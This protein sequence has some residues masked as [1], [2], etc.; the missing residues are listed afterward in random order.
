MFIRTLWA[1]PAILML[2]A[3]LPIAPLQAADCPVPRSGDTISEMLEK[4][5]T[6]A[7]ALKMFEACGYG[8]SIDVQFGATVTEKCEGDFLPKLSASQRKVYDR[9]KDA[10]TRKYAKQEGTMYRSFEAFCRAKLAAGYARKF[11]YIGADLTPAVRPWPFPRS[12]G[13]PPARRWRDR[14]A[15]CGRPA[16]P[17]CRDRR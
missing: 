14:R 12:P 10:C 13:M 4:A 16:R 15:P 3:P 2:I 17:P 9:E 1:L 11:K 6:C 7:D 5:P 8:S